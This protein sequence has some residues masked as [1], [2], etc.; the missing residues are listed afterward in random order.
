VEKNTTAASRNAPRYRVT[1]K[2]VPDDMTHRH[3]IHLKDLPTST[4]LK[5]LTGGIEWIFILNASRE[6]SNASLRSMDKQAV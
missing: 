5:I 1:D 6:F 2:R 4:K 3:T